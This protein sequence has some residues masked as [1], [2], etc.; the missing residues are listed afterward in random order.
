MALG[1]AAANLVAL[2]GAAANLVVPGEAVANLV[3]I[4]CSGTLPLVSRWLRNAV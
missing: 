2:G 3:V 1:G 4:A